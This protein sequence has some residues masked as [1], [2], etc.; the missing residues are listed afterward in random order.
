[1]FMA[2][3]YV[4]SIATFSAKDKSW[5]SL[6]HK[7]GDPILQAKDQSIFCQI[8]NSIR[9]QI[10]CTI[11]VMYLNHPKTITP[12]PGLWKSCLPAVVPWCQKYWGQVP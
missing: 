9:L 3:V 4:L 6:Y 10:N 7:A 1:M 12:N 5:Q 8:S 11:N 2:F